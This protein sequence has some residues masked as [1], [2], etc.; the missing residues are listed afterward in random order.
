[1]Q[2]YI[3]KR[4]KKKG[5]ENM[6]FSTHA[7]IYSNCEQGWEGAQRKGRNIKYFN[8]EGKC[9]LRRKFLIVQNNTFSQVIYIPVKFYM[10]NK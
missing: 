2:N 1:M 3:S 7:M 6:N 4:A 5:R 9:S 10:K 8:T